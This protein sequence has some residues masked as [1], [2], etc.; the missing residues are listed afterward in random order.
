MKTVIYTDDPQREICSLL[1]LFESRKFAS[2]KIK[3]R[4]RS[5]SEEALQSRFDG[6]TYS[7]RQARE[8]FSSSDHVSL[9]TRPLLLS[10]GMLNLGKAL[11]FYKSSEDTD[12]KTYFIYFAF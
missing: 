10:Y 4:C 8:F 3:E 9:L 6:I 7:V 1:G 11:V 5:L 2:D 12:F